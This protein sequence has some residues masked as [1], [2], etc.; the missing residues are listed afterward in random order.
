MNNGD[1]LTSERAA[2]APDASRN[3][4]PRPSTRGGRACGRRNGMA[5][6][7]YNYGEVEAMMKRITNRMHRRWNLWRPQME[8]LLAGAL[9][10]RQT[11]K[12]CFDAEV[13]GKRMGF[14]F[15]RL[16]GQRVHCEGMADMGILI[17]LKYTRGKSL[18]HV[19]GYG[20]GITEKGAMII[21]DFEAECAKAMSWH[22]QFTR[23]R[24][25]DVVIYLDRLDELKKRWRV[26]LLT[27]EQRALIRAINPE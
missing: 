23:R 14:S 25:E 18:K 17:R 27:D 22:D 9:L 19:N 24:L 6:N 26:P 5:R 3:H 12:V 16:P 20:F 1:E 2:A 8:L 7:G 11:D 4:S 13:L 21:Q 10:I 15:R